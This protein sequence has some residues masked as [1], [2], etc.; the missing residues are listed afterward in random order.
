MP[1]TKL[2]EKLR[3]WSFKRQHLDRREKSAL[4]VLEDVVGVYSSH[5]SG[6]LS[7]YAR[8]KSLTAESFLKLEEQLAVVRIPAMRLSVHVVPREY[9]RHILTATVPAPDDPYWAKRYSAKGR[10]IPENDYPGWRKQV[11]FLVKEPRAAKDIKRQAEIPD[12]KVKPVLN[13]M[14]CEGSLLRVGATNVR[15]NMVSYVA[16]RDWL[17]E[18]FHRQ[19]RDTALAWLAERYFK[20]FGPARMK[21]F[22]WWAGVTAAETKRAITA[23]NTSDIGDQHLLLANDLRSFEASK[24]Q[25]KGGLT[26]TPQ[27]DC[28]T[29]GYAPDGR[30]RFVTPDMQNRLYGS[31]GATRGN[32]SGAVLVNGL[33]HGSWS[34]RFKGKQAKFTLQMFDKAGSLLLKDLATH[35]G[36]LAAFLSAD[37]FSIDRM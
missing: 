37:E 33:A 22:Q 5:P 4:K 21:D 27:W 18:E 2:I 12:D 10:A 35:F 3:A 6:P 13:R 14:C 34:L 19:V 16:T 28:Y 15:S 11:L 29:M 30:G 36:E 8:T 7:L 26:L 23:L 24:P 25:K 32:A 17:G 1:T 31:L 20:A 9:A